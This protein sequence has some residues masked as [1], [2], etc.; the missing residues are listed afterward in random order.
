ML[1]DVNSPSID[2]ILALCDP[3]TDGRTDERTDEASDRQFNIELHG[4]IQKV[5][6]G[7]VAF[8]RSDFGQE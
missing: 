1:D 5:S 6:K 8:R 7:E 4:C 2:H 3:W